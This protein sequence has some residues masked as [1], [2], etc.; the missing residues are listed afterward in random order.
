MPFQLPA[1]TASQPFLSSIRDFHISNEVLTAYAMKLIDVGL[2][3]VAG[4]LLLFI[5]FRLL[6]RFNSW[7][8]AYLKDKPFDS[9]LKS[10]SRNLVNAGSKV[11]LI[12]MVLNVI[13]IRSTSLVAIL[14]A[15]GLAVGLALQGSLANFAGGV[16]LLLFKPFRVGDKIEVQG[17]TGKVTEIQIFNTVMQTAEERTVIIP[18][19]LVSNG[20]L[21]NFTFNQF[22][23]NEVIFDISTTADA[24]TVREELLEHLNKGFETKELSDISLDMIAFEKKYVSFSLQY[25]APNVPGA[26][27]PA[28]VREAIYY[29]L[30]SRNV[31]LA[32][33]D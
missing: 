16:L 24:K 2:R 19:G 17:K 9:T 15:A 6:N 28:Q 8:S 25:K 33:K 23:L 32:E 12:I 20:V 10:F 7:F 31:E 3:I 13:G 22:I 4:A 14:G 26:I 29:F 30:R 21:V 18:N 11:V 5:G 27:G 1:D